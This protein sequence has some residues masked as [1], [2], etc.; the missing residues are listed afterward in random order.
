MELIRHRILL[1]VRRPVESECYSPGCCQVMFHVDWD[2][3]RFLQTQYDIG[4]TQDLGMVITITGRSVNAQLA[5]VY[6]YLKQTWPTHTLTLLHAIQFAIRHND[7]LS[8]TGI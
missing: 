4:I 5:M 3:L 6:S 2:V 7:E 1:N 8:S